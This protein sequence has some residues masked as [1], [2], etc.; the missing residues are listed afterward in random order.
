[1]QDAADR[2]VSM[3]CPLTHAAWHCCVLLSCFYTTCQA[4]RLCGVADSLKI[5]AHLSQRAARHD[6]GGGAVPLA[7][8]CSALACARQ[9][10]CRARWGAREE[11]RTC[12]GCLQAIREKAPIGTAPRRGGS[13]FNRREFETL[14]TDKMM[15]LVFP[16][17]PRAIDGAHLSER[18]AEDAQRAQ[19]FEAHP[20]TDV[21]FPPGL[22]P[23]FAP[24]P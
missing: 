4:L 22:W 1:M 12:E 20:E 13:D 15:E 21:R 5:V 17:R 7:P 3:L 11:E 10:A 6:G 23:S 2:T 18:Q 9:V 16:E 19:F 24:R 8:L 14:L